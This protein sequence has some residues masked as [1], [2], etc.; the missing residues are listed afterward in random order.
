[1]AK[2]SYAHGASE[3]PLLGET[4]GANLAATAARQPD[5]E[6]LVDVRSGRRCTYAELLQWSRR[7]ARGL[8]AA[9][10]DK[11][12]RVAIWSPNCPEWVALQ[13][14]SALI[15]AIL[16]NVNPAYR[17]SELEYVLRQSG[18]KLLVSAVSYR[19]SDYRAMVEEVR[20]RV[21]G[22]QQVVFIGDPTW[23]EFEAAGDD[24][25]DSASYSVGL[26][27]LWTAAKNRT[28]TDAT[29]G[30][31]SFSLKGAKPAAPS[32]TTGG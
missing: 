32:T 23:N 19:T 20:P 27:Q 4:I 28:S 13:F 21:T 8:V 11:G 24:I 31:D 12:D 15:G 2:L 30:T 7:V 3:R 9:G 26:S 16:V 5:H 22:L 1:M 17:T 14:G 18:V 25:G 10:V 6:A 29:G